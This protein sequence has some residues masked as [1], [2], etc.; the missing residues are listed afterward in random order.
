MNCTKA[1]VIISILLVFMACAQAVDREISQ[2]TWEKNLRE[3][4][5]FGE[6]KW[7]MSEEE[8]RNVLASNKNIKFENNAKIIDVEN[9]EYS[10]FGPFPLL[11]N[12]SIFKIEGSLLLYF[13]K[14]KLSIICNAFNF[15]NI[16]DDYGADSLTIFEE[17]LQSLIKR[18]EDPLISIPIDNFD[19]YVNDVKNKIKQNE[20]D[21]FG[22][23]V[24][25]CNK[26][27]TEYVLYNYD[28]LEP[29][30]D[31]IEFRLYGPNSNKIEWQRY[32]GLIFD[33]KQLE[34]IP[35]MKISG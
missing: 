29:Y 13:F 2:T 11:K 15:K 30:I 1:T 31:S 19:K 10:R 9:S 32:S 21:L 18:Y 24:I 20:Q 17:Y 7:G 4:F 8:V 22:L 3:D 34:D 27:Q 23:M 28:R 12:P 16:K 35:Q 33:Y 6:L 26:E 25:W 5:F 14:G